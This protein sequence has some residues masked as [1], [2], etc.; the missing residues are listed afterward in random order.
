MLIT[1]FSSYQPI[2]SSPLR[3]YS[4]RL[5]EIRKI[6]SSFLDDSTCE[7]LLP[8]DF[9]RFFFPPLSPL[10]CPWV[11]LVTQTPCLLIPPLLLHLSN[12]AALTLPI[13]HHAPLQASTEGFPAPVGFRTG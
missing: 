4:A 6:E 12:I 9:I 11:A 3:D 7:L 2:W 13:S 5:D 10:K 1:F 8:H